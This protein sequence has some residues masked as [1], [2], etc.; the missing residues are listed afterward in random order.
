MCCFNLSDHS[1][2]VHKQLQWLKQHT[3]KIVEVTSPLDNWLSSL[4]LSVWL[5]DI[6]KRGPVI[7]LI[8][9]LALL[10]GLPSKSQSIRLSSVPVPGLSSVPV[11]VPVL[12]SPVPGIPSIAP[13]PFPVPFQFILIPSQFT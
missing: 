6:I 13:S 2:S 5:K 1:E 3:K 7:V 4:G 9:L 12:F 8:I 10:F 11:P